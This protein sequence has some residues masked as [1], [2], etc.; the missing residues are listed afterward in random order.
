[1]Q[2]GGR[3]IECELQSYEGS[4]CECQI[5][6]EDWCIYRRRWTIRAHALADA[7]Q[8]RQDLLHDGWTMDEDRLPRPIRSSK[9]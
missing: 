8:H 1:M 9:S 4:A 2:K 6:D 5:F 3:L 7:E